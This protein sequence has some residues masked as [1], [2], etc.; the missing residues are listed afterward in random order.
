MRKKLLWGFTTLFLCVLA[1]VEQ[2]QMSYLNSKV[3]RLENYSFNGERIVFLGDSITNR[4]DVDKYFSSHYVINSGIGGNQTLDIL[5]DLDNRVFQYN[6]SKVILLIGTNDLVYS[7]LDLDA[8]N[9]NI[10]KIIDEINGN[11]SS[12]KI[13]LE[14]IYPV[15]NAVNEEMVDGRKNE[16]I[17]ELND[18]IRSI[19]ESDRCVYID[20]FDK[21]VDRN[22]NL[23][24]I[25]TVDGIHLSKVGYRR[26]TKEL[27]RYVD[28]ERMK[29]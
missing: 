7:G 26:V 25:Y 4:Y 8:I 12:I 6:P 19:C 21:L 3:E 18:K 11:D 20:M 16:D 17:K 29:E 13:Y 22:G 24:R 15:N 23:K 2:R 5:N 10:E 14:S 1:C 27:L 28:D 9:G